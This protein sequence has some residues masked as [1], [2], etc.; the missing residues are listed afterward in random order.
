MSVRRLCLASALALVPVAAISQSADPYYAG[1]LVQQSAVDTARG[2]DYAGGLGLV[3]GMPLGN[4]LGF[5]LNG[6]AQVLR[7]KANKQNES[8]YGLGAD[9]TINRLLSRYIT[10]FALGGF[11]AVYEEEDNDSEARPFADVG[12]GFFTQVPVTPLFFRGDLRYRSVFAGSSAAKS[13]YGDVVV[14]LGVQLPFGAKKTNYSLVRDSDRDGVVDAS[15]ICGSTPEGMPV[16]PKGCPMRTARGDDDRDGV[17]DAA[18]NCPGVGVAGAVDQRGCP[19]DSAASQQQEPVPLLV[20]DTSKTVPTVGASELAAAPEA[21]TASASATAES[22]T[23]DSAATAAS[24]AVDA[25]VAAA[26]SSADPI[27]AL[28]AA[29]SAEPVSAAPI[30]AA[31]DAAPAPVQAAASDTAAPVIAAATDSEASA[32]VQVAAAATAKGAMV[33]SSRNLTQDPMAAVRETP[34]LVL[35]STPAVS[36]SAAVTASV[37]PE[38]VA[39]SKSSEA[40][41]PVIADASAAEATPPVA[42]TASVAAEAAAVATAAAVVSAPSSAEIAKATAA[43]AAGKKPK[44]TEPPDGPSG[45]VLNPIVVPDAPIPVLS[46]S[47]DTDQDGVANAVDRCEASAAGL[48]L[49]AEGCVKAQTLNYAALEFEGATAKLNG[50]GKKAAAALAATLKAQPE[51]RLEVN[52]HTDS[53]GPQSANLTLSQKRANAVMAELVANGVPKS[54]IEA[55]GYGEFIPVA[56][57]STVQGR[58]LNRRIELKFSLPFV[59]RPLN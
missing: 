8:S 18:D 53:L 38:A 22:A 31:A 19:L 23:P 39:E 27:G 44:A 33:T 59:E 45:V 3:W 13:T 10:G 42:V 47:D 2:G 14:N 54:Q 21:V 55:E 1:I 32:A 20:L 9:F 36:A 24:A 41:T 37:A 56:D 15:D 30:I 5:E 35:E 58:A 52:A 46:V 34:E 25:S 40:A 16:D 50:K 26:N 12:L 17:I 43:V 57:N 11:G 4:Q 6:F 49:S 29:T 7:N 51:L 48:G 28:A